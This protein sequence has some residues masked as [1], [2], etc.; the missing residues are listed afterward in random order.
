MPKATE[1]LVFI[2]VALNY[3][4]KIPVGY[5]LIHELTAEEKANLL[6]TCLININETG[7]IVKTLTFDGVASNISMAKHLGADLTNQISW[8]PHP[9]TQEEITIFLDPAHMLKLVS[10]TIGDWGILYDAEDNPIEWKYFKNL[11]TLQENNK[12]NLAT[13]IRHRHINYFKEKMKVRLAAQV[14]S[15][16]VANALL[17]CK[18]KNIEDFNNCDLTFC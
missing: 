13:K 16:S 10:N 14:F 11:V 8:F 12:I 17:Y 5:F 7:A 15:C 4:W 18:T 1:A 9:S 3:H 6:K 2:V